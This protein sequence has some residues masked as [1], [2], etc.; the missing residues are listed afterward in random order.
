MTPRDTPRLSKDWWVRERPADTVARD[1]EQALFQ[2]ERAM[3]A[4]LKNSADPRGIDQCL[5]ALKAV[6]GAAQKAIRECDKNNHQDVVHVLKRFPRLVKSEIKRFEALRKQ[7]E[8][9]RKQTEA[10]EP[11]D[12]KVFDKAYL[13]QRIKWLRNSRGKPLL[14]ALGMNRSDPKS[15]ILVLHRK[16]KPETLMKLVMKKGITKKM[17]AY[18]TARA[19]PQQAKTLILDLM[20]APPP[21]FEK[22]GRRFLRANK[23]LKFKNLQVSFGRATASGPGS[24]DNSPDSK[25]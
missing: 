14:F 21:G 20:S 19:H 1:L 10:D 24:E 3:S 16:G 9:E 5:R 4:Q 11:S 23:E 8:D 6:P 2:A 12:H 7:L 18:G 17:I 15:S 13:L 25:P 22:K